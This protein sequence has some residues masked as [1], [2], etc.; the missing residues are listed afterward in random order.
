VFIDLGRDRILRAEPCCT[1]H[2]IGGHVVYPRIGRELAERRRAVGAHH[3]A[4]PVGS[5]LTPRCPRGSPVTR[6]PG[7]RTTTLL[8]DSPVRQ[9]AEGVHILQVRIPEDATPASQV[10]FAHPQAS[11]EKPPCDLHMLSIVPAHARGGKYASRQLPR[12]NC[13]RGERVS[14][15]QLPRGMGVDIPPER[16]NTSLITA[17][18]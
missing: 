1:F 8:Y 17:E 12:S 4:A 6:W 2:G 3:V 15:R 13:L 7:F 18:T 9:G 11:M 10:A 14:L 5:G 16:S